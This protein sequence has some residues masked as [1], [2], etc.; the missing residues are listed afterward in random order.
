MKSHTSFAHHPP[1]S[2]LRT[3]SAGTQRLERPRR[4][5]Q[6]SDT[7]SAVAAAA[8]PP[9]A[10]RRASASFARA[11]RRSAGSVARVH[12][13]RAGRNRAAVAPPAPPP[14]PRSRPGASS[15]RWPRHRHAE[16]A[17]PPLAHQQ[18]P[19][20]QLARG[21]RERERLE[22][23]RARVVV[24][25]DGAHDAVAEARAEGRR[26]ASS[27][28]DALSTVVT[29]VRPSRATTTRSRHR[30]ARRA[31]PSA[32]T[33]LPR[34]SSGCTR[35]A[36]ALPRASRVAHALQRR[37]GAHVVPAEV[38]GQ[39]EHARAALEHP[40]V[41]GDRRRDRARRTPPGHRRAPASCGATSGVCAPHLVEEVADAPHEDPRVPQVA[42][43]APS[44]GARA[45][46]LLDEA[47]H[48]AHARPRAPRPAGCSRSR[49]PAASGTMPTV[50]SACVRSAASAARGERLRGTPSSSPIAQ[51]ACTQIITASSPAR[52]ARSA[53]AAQ[54]SAAAVPAGRGSAIRFSARNAGAPARAMGATRP[55]FVST[56]VRSGGTSGASRAS[57]SASS[58]SSVA[59]GEQLLRPLRSAHRPEARADAAG[60]DHGPAAHDA[61]ALR[62]LGR[63]AGQLGGARVQ[64]LRAERLRQELAR[65]QLHAP[66]DAAAP[67]PRP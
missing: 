65:A 7:G 52:G 6:N 23:A 27:G 13:P 10:R 45:V 44:R 2:A 31:F 38:A 55:A 26:S 30:T 33:T 39:H 34:A 64:L 36:S 60:E 18:R 4:R 46:G 62:L 29:S 50:T 12:D 66:C 14:A 57:A 54:A 28:R 25:V 8:P 58:G 61:P 43:R 24:E 40:D 48:A 47:R 22:A 37:P 20:P 9:R 5:R 16:R 51:S 32:C 15:V 59:S 67:G 49:G 56:S 63:H 17:R 42:L 35:P 1:L 41:H 3:P 11:R 19:R 21:P 53:C